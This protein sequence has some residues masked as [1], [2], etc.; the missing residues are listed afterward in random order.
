MTKQISTD[1]S[2]QILH[3]KP[4]S[5]PATFEVTV[6]NDSDRFAAFQVELSA[7]GSEPTLGSSWYRLV[8]AI[9]SKIPGGDST[10]FQ[11]EILA[12]PPVPGGFTGTMNLTVRV[13]SL[14]LQDEDRQILRLVVEGTGVLPAKLELPVRQFQGYPGDEIEVLVAV[15]NSNRQAVD[16]TLRLGGVELNWFPDGFEKPLHIAAGGQ[17][18]VMFLCQLPEAVQAPSRVYPLTVEA[19]QP[20]AV[21]VR[22]QAT[23]TVL[24]AGYVE[25]RCNPMRQQ[26]PMRPRRWLNP[27]VD[28]ATYDLELDN[29]SNLPQQA[30]VEVY[31]PDEKGQRR[32][33]NFPWSR[34]DRKVAA[35]PTVNTLDL[36]PPAANLDVGGT[37]PLT[38]LVRRRLPW[39]GWR[40]RQWFQ[41]KAIISDSRLDLRND[42]QTLELEILPIIPFWLQLLGGLL[43]LL[44]FWICWWWLQ[45]QGHSGPVTAV[46]LNG[47]ANEVVSVSTDGTIRRW[48]VNGSHLIPSGVLERGDK[49]MRVVRYR[50]VNNDELAAGFENGEIQVWNLLFG[51]R[52][53]SFVYRK[54]DRVFDLAF[55]QDSRFLFSGH[56][57][58]LV[59]QW[60]IEPGQG[61][62][63]QAKPV[64]GFKVNFAV[65]S[66]ALLGATDSDLAIAGRFNQLVLLNL[67]KETF[68]AVPYRKGGFNDYILSLA[69]ASQQRELLATA[70]NRGTIALWNLN[71]CLADPKA[72]CQQVDEWSNGHGGAAVRS[73]ALSADGCYLVS[74]G[75]DGRVVLWPLT[76]QGTRNSAQREGK[77]LYQ[78]SLP[79]NAVDLIRTK[80]RILVTSGG[81]D[82]QVRLHSVDQ[83]AVQAG[84]TCGTFAQ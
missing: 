3:F 62:L 79:I 36:V 65:Q 12:V 5:V 25:F 68:R 18:K 50:P 22:A 66:L 84:G 1:I 10:H 31:D 30:R 52:Q 17:T 26:L 76:S 63:V 35:K 15:G 43:G 67:A 83:T 37:A 41:A 42:T 44:I 8:P 45:H 9:S 72:P 53:S 13:F 75:D 19:I 39:F 21:P 58:G 49:A 55:T 82:F 6:Y 71:R 40:R 20:R 28:T 2:T 33:W 51:E 47:R 70:D 29:Q 24:P 7:A 60:G 16:L 59:F 81:Q 80:D 77:M 61:A 14:E 57:S 32:G 38:L 78:S 56:G 4:G 54:D 23:L 73:V 46:R 64:R 34:S 11:V 48:Q 69:T 74:A 27:S